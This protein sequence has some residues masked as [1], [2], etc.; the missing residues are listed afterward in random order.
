MFPMIYDKH[1]LGNKGTFFENHNNYYTCVKE[2]GMGFMGIK[3]VQRTHFNSLAKTR[4]SIV[5]N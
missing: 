4:Q 2:L 3:L 5:H 1:M